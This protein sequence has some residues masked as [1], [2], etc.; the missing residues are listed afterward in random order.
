MITISLIIP[1]FNR[2]DCLINALSS[3]MECDVLPNEVIIS[4]Q[5]EP[6]LFNRID[7]EINKCKSTLRGSSIAWKHIFCKSVGITASRNAGLREATS[8]VIVFTDDDVLYPKS[9]FSNVVDAFKDERVGMMGGVNLK[10]FP[11]DNY[12]FA[13]RAFLSFLGLYSWIRKRGAVSF[14]LF[15]SY[16]RNFTNQVPTEWAMGY[17]MIFRRSHLLDSKLQFDEK[18][19]RYAFNEDLELTYLFSKWAAKRNIKC[20]LRSDIG[21]FHMVSKENR[22]N[23]ELAYLRAFINRQYINYVLYKNSL[24]RRFL[25]GWSNFWF[26]A[27]RIIQNKDDKGPIRA[28][29]KRFLRVKPQLNKGLIDESFYDCK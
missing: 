4:D 5:N 3:L 9:F 16:P 7:D 1:T 12:S 29:Y 23:K 27:L 8:D 22:E 24:W 20:Y 25:L 11:K 26:K 13:I 2:F 18:L 10:E 21:V 17:C 15:G 19:S 14:G 28:A 6:D